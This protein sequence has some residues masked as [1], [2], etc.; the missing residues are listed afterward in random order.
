MKWND[1]YA[2]LALL[3]IIA[4]EIVHLYDQRYALLGLQF[5]PDLDAVCVRLLAVVEAAR[6]TVVGNWIDDRQARIEA[7]I[8]DLLR[9]Q[10]RPDADDE[11][12]F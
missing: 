1:R 2:A 7:E 5:E 4:R 9:D 12:P 3:V 11:L 10:Y 8:S 6:P